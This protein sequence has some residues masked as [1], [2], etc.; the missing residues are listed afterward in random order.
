MIRV[1]SYKIQLLP[2]DFQK[3]VDIEPHLRRDWN[4]V[5]DLSGESRG[6][7]V[8]HGGGAN[9]VQQIKLFDADSIDLVQYKDRR[10]IYTVDISR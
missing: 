1:H 6:P 9:L 3:L 7:R 5:R 8:K 2:H 10:H 4:R